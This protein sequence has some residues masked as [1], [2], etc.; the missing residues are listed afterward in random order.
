VESDEGLGG[1]RPS[2]EILARFGKP[3]ASPPTEHAPPVHKRLGRSSFWV[4][5]LTTLI[6]VLGVA[7][8]AWI[9]HT[10]GRSE[11][12]YAIWGVITFYLLIASSI[13]WLGDLRVGSAY[14]YYVSRGQPAR[15]LTGT[16]LGLRL[17]LVSLIGFSVLPLSYFL[18]GELNFSLSAAQYLSIGL[19]LLLPI[20]WTPWMVISQLRIAR[21]YSIA[22]QYPQ[23]VEV[24][25]RSVAIVATIYLDPGLLGFTYAFVI[26]GVASF[27]YCLPELWREMS[28]PARA[29]AVQLLRYSWP[30]MGSLM[31]QFLASNAPPFFVTGLLRSSLLFNAFNWDNGWRILL[32][33]VPSA[34]VLPLFPYLASFHARGDYALV[35]QKTWEALRFTAMMILP[36]A[37]LIVVYRVPLANFISNDRT[38]DLGASA[39]VLL[40]I[41]AFPLGLSQVIGTAL[42]S[43]GYQRLELYISG[44]IVAAMVAF[45]VGLFLIYH[46]LAAI[47]G[48]VLAG[49]VAALALNTYFM[50]HL[51]RVRIRVIPILRIT[52]AAAGAFLAM[53]VVNRYVPA[54]SVWIFAVLLVLGFAVYALIL[55]AIGELSKGDVNLVVGAVGLPPALGRALAKLCWRAEPSS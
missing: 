54:S 4:F 47:A 33:S 8:S 46:D 5:I 45:A 36:A 44:T 29:R 22:A 52:V 27:L 49:S 6:Q 16:Y 32:L 40:A 42:N 39:L 12:G 11:S 31:F 19:F 24:M 35:Q 9:Y 14:T 37:L 18:G 28:Q 17:A 38:A 13:N 55:A 51:L 41:S 10:F 3:A 7:S 25:V 1:Y 2:P 43:I 21:G 53:D 50:E 23:F 34:V 30:L 20:L 15:E 26:G 48:G